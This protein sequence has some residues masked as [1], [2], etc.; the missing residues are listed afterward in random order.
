MSLLIETHVCNIELYPRLI[1]EIWTSTDIEHFQF[2]DIGTEFLV[3]FISNLLTKPFVYC[4]LWN[5]NCSPIIGTFKTGMIKNIA[6][7]N[8]K[9][10]PAA[11]SDTWGLIRFVCDG[12]GG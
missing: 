2:S 5:W 8:M 1:H 3:P 11:E 9:K 6:D 4:D 7:L 10:G 12:G